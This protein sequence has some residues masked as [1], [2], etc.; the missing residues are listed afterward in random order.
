[1]RVIE[2][3]NEIRMNTKTLDKYLDSKTDPE[4]SFA[5][6]LV[7]RGICFV[8]VKENGA[9]RFCPSRFVGYADN[10]MDTH[11]SEHKYGGDTNRAISAVLGGNPR[12]NPT[13][14][15]LYRE[16]CESLGFIANERGTFGVERKYWEI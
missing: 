11:L 6:D 8:V 1:M 10:C 2:G 3:L 7:K 9:Y 16:Y 5:I 4:Y 15:N 13:L 12:P 14:D